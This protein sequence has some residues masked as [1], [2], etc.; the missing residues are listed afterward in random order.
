MSMSANINIENDD[1]TYCTMSG[2]MGALKTA[3]SGCVEPLAEPSADKME[4]VG[5]LV[6]VM[7][8]WQTSVC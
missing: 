1:V 3:G 7:V 6:I 2:R 8:D 5:R 4:T